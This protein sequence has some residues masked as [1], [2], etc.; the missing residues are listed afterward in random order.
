MREAAERS[1]AEP[2][3][4]DDQ[5]FVAPTPEARRRYIDWVSAVSR[6]R[7]PAKPARFKGK[8]WRL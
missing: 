2:P 8:H 1:Q 4:R 7:S 3:L 6:L 5:R